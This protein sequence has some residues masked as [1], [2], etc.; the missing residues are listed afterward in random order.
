MTMRKGAVM[1]GREFLKRLRL[2]SGR[3]ET[4]KTRYELDES[5]RL[6]EHVTVETHD[7][8]LR[9]EEHALGLPKRPKVLKVY[10]GKP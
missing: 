9:N 4:I 3:S 2:L 6:V 1:I 5:G 10:R 8:P 7:P